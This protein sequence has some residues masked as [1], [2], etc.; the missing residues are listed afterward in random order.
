[1]WRDVG[2]DGQ[3][4]EASLGEDERGESAGALI[5]GGDQYAVV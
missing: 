4:G 2:V 3:G 5:V 1:M